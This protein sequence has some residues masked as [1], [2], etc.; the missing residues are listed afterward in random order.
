MS[1]YTIKVP[2]TI[3]A[4]IHLDENDNPINEYTTVDDAAVEFTL[5]DA[6]VTKLVGGPHGSRPVGEQPVTGIERQR[7]LS[8]ANDASWPIAEWLGDFK[9]PDR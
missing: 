5:D 4:Q 3:W 9:G 1:D 8:A 7:V 2:A 6:I